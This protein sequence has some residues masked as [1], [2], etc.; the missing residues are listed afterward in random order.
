M[1]ERRRWWAKRM[2]GRETD[3]LPLFFHCGHALVIPEPHAV[4]V[5]FCPLMGSKRQ[6]PP[7]CI[8]WRKSKDRRV[9][10]RREPK[11]LNAGKEGGTKWFLFLF[12]LL[13]AL[14]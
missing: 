13:S 9:G 3:I 1:K 4:F 8:V 10:L 6:K 2:E 11:H 5:H 7:F 12:F 14:E